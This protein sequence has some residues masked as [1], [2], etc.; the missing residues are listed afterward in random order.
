MD[1]VIAG[2]VVLFIAAAYQDYKK[3]EVS[4]YLT[5][6]AWILSAFVFNLQYFILFF[7]GV[8]AIASLFERIKMPFIAFGDI[9]FF[10][11]FS[12]ILLYLGQNDILFSLITMLV[13]QVYLWYQLEWNKTPKEKV[14]GSPFVLVML[15]MLIVAFL[16][17]AFFG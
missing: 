12:G 5:I 3:R 2:I 6:F 8:W 10:P 16:L 17:K 4:D 14:R 13:A 9:L 7:C 1:Y 11:V 15:G